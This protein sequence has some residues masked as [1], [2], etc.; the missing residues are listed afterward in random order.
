[1]AEVAVQLKIMPSSPD[2]DLKIL[3]DE[4]A[5]RVAQFGRI[6]SSEE[7][8]IAFGLTA[9]LLTVIIE[10]KEG[11]TEALETSISEIDAIESVQAVAVTRMI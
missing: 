5:S 11:G 3:S 9:L 4:I 1:M 8:P 7:S 6:H 10:D 2:I